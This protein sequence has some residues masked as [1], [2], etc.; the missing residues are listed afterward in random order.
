MNFFK[1]QSSNT[2]PDLLSQSFTKE[3]KGLE[4]FKGFCCPIPTYAFIKVISC[5]N[6]SPESSD[7]KS[8]KNFVE[9][10]KKYIL[11][12]NISNNFEN[13]A[14]SLSVQQIIECN[15]DTEKNSDRDESESIWSLPSKNNVEPSYKQL[16]QKIK[17]LPWK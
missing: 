7:C 15:N 5:E 2:V 14:K 10:E 8:Q 3:L 16:R 13:R 1:N 12:Q 17:L 9:N 4:K 6:L 11:G